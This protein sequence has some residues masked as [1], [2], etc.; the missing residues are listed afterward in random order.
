MLRFLK[1]VRSLLLIELVGLSEQDVYGP[2]GRG[3]PV[4]EL[5]ILL[6][7]SAPDVDDQEES[8]KT[9]PFRQRIDELRPLALF[10]RG[11]LGI[12][13]TRQVDDACAGL[14]LEKVK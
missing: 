11:R 4:D 9:L 5:E 2:S 12:A 8:R 6:A 1:G 13:I 14:Q 7:E 10:G 3:G